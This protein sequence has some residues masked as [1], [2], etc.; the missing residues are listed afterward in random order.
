MKRSTSAPASRAKA[1]PPLTPQQLEAAMREAAE[2]RVARRDEEAIS[3]Y[4][5]I[6]ARSPEAVDAAY[7]LALIDLARYRPADA[8]PRLE[9]LTRRRPRDGGF[10][11]AVFYTRRELGQWSE[12]LEALAQ[13]KRLRPAAP[14]PDRPAVL[15]V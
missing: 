9:S 7:Y 1:G 10:W 14:Q 4:S 2:H 8:L 3:F 11:T 12:A 5:Q 15:E 13:V 6:E